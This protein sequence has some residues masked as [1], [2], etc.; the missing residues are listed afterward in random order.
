MKSFSE[1]Y[2]DF[3]VVSRQ[4]QIASIVDSLLVVSG[5]LLT[6]SALILI[7]LWQLPW[8]IVWKLLSIRKTAG[9]YYIP[10]ILI[11]L[12]LSWAIKSH[13]SALEDSADL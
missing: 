4:E 8:R 3:Q 12:L 5:L 11:V 10:S 2:E 7:T 9:A 6:F 1:W 13:F